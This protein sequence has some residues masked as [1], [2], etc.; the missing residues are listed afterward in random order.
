MKFQEF[1]RINNFIT[2]NHTKPHFSRS[3]SRMGF[4]FPFRKA[5]FG[6]VEALN[7]ICRVGLWLILI[8]RI[9]I[10]QFV[11][12]LIENFHVWDSRWYSDILYYSIIIYHITSYYIS[13]YIIWLYDII[14]FDRYFMYP[15]PGPTWERGCIGLGLYW[16]NITCFIFQILMHAKK[17]VKISVLRTCDIFKIWESNHVSKNTQNAK[18]P[19]LH[20]KNARQHTTK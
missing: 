4:P 12:E 9:S 16:M 19:V 8:A 15:E 18:P 3:G 20:W 14:H 11:D 17:A 1:Q 7:Q 2:L 10:Y 6:W 13:V 5:W